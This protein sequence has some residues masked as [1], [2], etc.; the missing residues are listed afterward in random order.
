MQKDRIFHSLRTWL[1]NTL[2]KFHSL[3]SRKHTLKTEINVK[4]LTTIW[5]D[6][7]G[8]KKE[9]GVAIFLRYSF[10]VEARHIFQWQLWSNIYLQQH[11]LFSNNWAPQVTSCITIALYAL[12][13]KYQ[14]I[15]F[16]RQ[17][18]PDNILMM[19]DFNFP[20][21]TCIP[22][23]KKPRW[24]PY[25]KLWIYLSCPSSCFFQQDWSSMFWI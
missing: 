2:L 12:F 14:Y 9:E 24:N 16:I 17:F 4:N 11:K 7:N 8:R 15:F 3:S 18:H 23:P 5:A 10:T 21:G 25:S 1:S 13:H 6:R 19:S 22:T 20:V